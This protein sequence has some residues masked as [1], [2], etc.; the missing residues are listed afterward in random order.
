MISDRDGKELFRGDECRY[1]GSALTL[2]GETVRIASEQTDARQ[3]VV[4]MIVARQTTA[5]FDEKDLILVRRWTA[6]TGVW[7]DVG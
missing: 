5:A 7:E 4:G 1:V 2:L 6:E 3:S